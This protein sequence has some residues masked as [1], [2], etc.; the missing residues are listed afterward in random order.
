MNHHE[1]LKPDPLIGAA[2]RWVEGEV[3]LE[4]VDWAEMRS[5]IRP[6]AS[7]PLARRRAMQVASPRW[8]KPLIPLAAA[9]GLATVFWLGIGREDSSLPAST[10]VAVATPVSIQEALLSDVSDQEFR[11]L[12]A[13]R[14]ADELLMI[15]ASQ[16]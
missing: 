3:P 5:N 4:E 2:L 16:R 13:D 11:L 15:A 7:L 14:D 9:A 1:E 10:P 6:R 12:V 8:V